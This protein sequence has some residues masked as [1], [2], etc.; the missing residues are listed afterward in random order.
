MSGPAQTPPGWYPDP[1]DPG[2][3]R[4][5]DGAQWTESRAPVGQANV[6]TNG[7]A[8][9]SVA[10]ILADAR[11]AAKGPAPPA[12]TPPNRLPF[13]PLPPRDVFTALPRT[14]GEG[15]FIGGLPQSRSAS[16]SEA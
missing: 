5:W 7:K 1:H 14:P 2:T 9:A 11:A 15:F 3:Q 4:Y 10:R 13:R 16:K 12:A 6:P 8:I